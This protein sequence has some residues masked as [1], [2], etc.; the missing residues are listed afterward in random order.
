MKPLLDPGDQTIDNTNVG[1]SHRNR[2]Q[3][4]ALVAALAVAALLVQ[5][6]GN[7]VSESDALGGPAWIWIVVVAVAG[8]LTGAQVFGPV[9][10]AW[11]RWAALAGALVAGTFFGSRADLPKGSPSSI[12]QIELA[13][14][15]GRV[16]R[17]DC[18]ATLRDSI[19]YDFGFIAAYVAL[20]VLL[21]AWAG[22]YYR[23]GVVRDART[24][25]VSASIAA[26]FL[27]VVE[28]K[29]MLR[30]IGHHDTDFWW[31]TASVCAWAKWVLVLVVVGY[32][33]GGVFAWWVTPT[34]IRIASWRLYADVRDS[35]DS[36]RRATPPKAMTREGSTEQLDVSQP[37]KL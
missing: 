5:L 23:L 8:V 13:G 18:V 10:A 12:V 26:G 6:H 30:G 25:M 32:V 17:C 22:C 15:W 16:D 27:D 3:L 19:H 21:V 20:L 33:A 28:D 31:Q 24:L 7:G 4:P 29:A 37:L 2:V 9:R 14:N 34:W 36:A 1:F 11:A 35:E